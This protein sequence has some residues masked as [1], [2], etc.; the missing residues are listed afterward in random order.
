MFPQVEILPGPGT[1][2]TES[3]TI[4][5]FGPSYGSMVGAANATVSII[6]GA[7][8]AN[9]AAD[10]SI[11]LLLPP[12][13]LPPDFGTRFVAD[14]AAA[15]GVGAARFSL[16]S[17]SGYGG[18]TVVVVRMLPNGAG[19]AAG[20]TAVGLYLQLKND[21]ANPSSAIWAAGSLTRSIDPTY[22]PTAVFL[23]LPPAPAPAPP[24]PPPGMSWQ[25]VLLIVLGVG[26]LAAGAAAWWRRKALTEWVLWRLASFRFTTLRDHADEPEGVELEPPTSAA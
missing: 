6:G 7:S 1:D 11:D 9:D 21:V 2:P 18:V 19:A 15:L 10:V 4:G 25:S 3:F 13:A 20:P 23:A 8:Y 12:G 22:P 16:M 17:V 26:A 24:P 5:L 14:L